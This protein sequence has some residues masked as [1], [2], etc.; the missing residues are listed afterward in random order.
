M[1]LRKEVS[2]S[3]QIGICKIQIV[4]TEIPIVIPRQQG[5]LINIINSGNVATH[6]SATVI[7]IEGYP[8]TQDFSIKP[9]N[10]FLHVG[11]KSSFLIVYKPQCF[12]ANSV[13]NER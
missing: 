1:I 8:N 2:L 10:I 3:A 13:D 9:D 11:E 7:P 5:K 12:N 4:D 6:V